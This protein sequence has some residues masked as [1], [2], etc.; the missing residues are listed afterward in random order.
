MKAEARVKRDL[1]KLATEGNRLRGPHTDSLGHG[2]FELRT[3]H[4]GNIFRH[5]FMYYMS[6]IV[7]VLS[8]I[9]KSQKIPKNILKLAKDRRAEILSGEAKGEQAT[10][11]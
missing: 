6:D 8:F 11:H 2:L 10:I 5:I 4:D 1:Q 7:I 9:K 3:Q